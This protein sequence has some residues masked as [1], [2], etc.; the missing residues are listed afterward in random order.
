MVELDFCP[1]SLD[2]VTRDFAHVLADQFC[3]SPE[4]VVRRLREVICVEATLLA[5]AAEEVQDGRAQRR[6]GNCGDAGGCEDGFEEHG[7]GMK[8]SGLVQADMD[9]EIRF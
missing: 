9:V 5:E 8:A 4:P 1:G 7:S 6:E 3:V 2:V